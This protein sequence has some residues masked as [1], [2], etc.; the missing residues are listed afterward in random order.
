MD[1]IEI[2]VVDDT[3]ES[4]RLLS[5]LLR[6]NGYNVRPTTN[7]QLALS[8]ALENPPDL[9]LLDIKMPDMNGFEL[10]QALKQDQRTAAVPVIFIS[11]LHDVEDQVR[12]FEVGGVDFITKPIE[13][14]IVLTRINTHLRLS[15]ALQELAQT[16]VDLAK[17][18]DKAEA[19]SK[20]KSL[21]LANVS[22]E[23][24]APL[25]SILGFTEI[26]GW[27]ARPEQKEDLGIISQCGE[28]LLAMINDIL[29]LS[30]IEAGRLELHPEAINL[31]HML[32]G[33]G[34]MFVTR[35]QN[36]ELDFR[37]ELNDN[38]SPAIKIDPGK[39]RQILINLLG[40]AIKFTSEGFVA[41]RASTE[42]IPHE[43]GLANLKLE[44]EDSG[45]GISQAELIHIF[46]P[47]HQGGHQPSAAKGTGLGLSITK[48]LIELMS[49]D[50]KVESKEKEGTCF[51]ISIP[52]ALADIKETTLDEDTSKEVHKLAP[53]QEEKR[54]LIVDDDPLS[55]RLMCSLL[56]Q[57][58][59][60]CREAQNG[61]E[62]IEQF[63]TW[64][65]H[66]IWMDLRMPQID[67]YEAARAIR[68][69]TNGKDLPIMALTASAFS[70]QHQQIIDAGFDGI[71]HK[72]FHSQEIYDIMQKYLGV[73]Y[74]YQS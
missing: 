38:L 41:L 34:Q 50:I 70:G 30:R 42:A 29:D 19:A 59:F 56:S 44:I 52:V 39:L 26:L 48:S 21:F 4:L 58:G 24:R 15:K 22:H 32:E 27:E 68:A 61:S 9:A 63:K 2:L 35:S 57:V 3:A 72:P 45:D 47:F 74:I 28:H 1:N 7:P 69:T 36:A 53:G 17:A 37:L 6:A 62:A 51:Y 10:C 46:E 40:N 49:G 71:L 16:N 64:A 20:A 33:I 60:E 73:E 55:Q 14:Q 31:W 65:P 54:I 12:G 8:S 13:R 67:G 23:L 25:S 43:P 66:F 18:R 5:N 11:A